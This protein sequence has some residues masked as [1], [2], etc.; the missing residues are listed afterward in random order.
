MTG[1][2]SSFSFWGKGVEG[3]EN[4]GGIRI[5][6]KWEWHEKSFSKPRRS[7]PFSKTREGDFPTKDELK[8]PWFPSRTPFRPSCCEIGKKKCFFAQ[9]AHAIFPKKLVFKFKLFWCLFGF[10]KTALSVG[11]RLGVFTGLKLSTIFSISIDKGANRTK[12]KLRMRMKRLRVRSVVVELS[13]QKKARL[14]LRL[15]VRDCWTKVFCF[16]HRKKSRMTA[17]LGQTRMSSTLD[18][19]TQ[20]LEVLNTF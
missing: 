16:F 4:N 8:N 2:S 19:E 15:I 20:F 10:L 12:I 17:F 9:L 14:L 6:P 1:T 11:P 7:L 13:W 3:K 5:G 18:L